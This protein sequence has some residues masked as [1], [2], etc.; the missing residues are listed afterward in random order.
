MGTELRTAQEALE[1]P[2]NEH[3]RNARD[4]LF[5]FAGIPYLVVIMYQ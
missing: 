5:S 2:D 1:N 4:M 3:A